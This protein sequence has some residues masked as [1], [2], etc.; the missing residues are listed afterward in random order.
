MT[1]IFR[2]LGKYRLAAGMAVLMMLIELALELIQPFLIAVI[3]DEG[4]TQKDT[5]VVLLWGGL[6]VGGSIVAFGAGILSSFFA[7]HTSQGFAFDIR[8]ALYTKVQAFSYAVFNRFATSSLITRLTND[9]TQLLDTVFMGLRFML[10]MPLVVIGSIVMALVV[11]LQLGLLLTLT[12][13]ALLVFVVWI[14]KKASVL[15][16]KV[17][18]KLDT[19]NRVMQENLTGMRLIRVFVRRK[20]EAGRFDRLSGELMGSTVSALRLT[21]MTMPFILLIMNA[22]IIAVL[23]FGH[24]QIGVGSATSGEV[25]AV[26]NYSLRTAGALSAFSMIVATLSRARASAQRID[27]ALETDSK[28]RVHS[29]HIPVESCAGSVEFDQVSFLYPHTDARVL[30]DISFKIQPGETAAIMGATGS[31]KSSLMQLVLRLY[32]QTAGVVRIDGRDARELDLEFL[33]RS[34]GYVS[35]EVLLFSGTIR[36]NIAWGLEDASMEQVVEAA[37]MAQIHET[38][39]KLP[40]GYQT[41]LGQRGINLSGGQKQ[42]LSIARALIRKPAILLLDDSTSALDVRTEAAL[43]H[44]LKEMA[45]TTLLI[46]QKISSTVGADQILLL[47]EGSLIAQGTHEQ[48]MAGNSLYR[49][50]YESQFGKEGTAHVGSFK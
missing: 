48:L 45:C 1:I 24:Q 13:P 40:D 18:M 9:V 25:V 31:G 20:E 47:D 7:S 3:I 30:T 46:T 10:R 21:E 19:V 11:H 5:S 44:A 50:I 36:D 22:G 38:I 35:Q 42:R 6:L 43:L 14:M 33:H 41:Q 27:E 26:V 16:K 28:A 34:I 12:V 8:E 29:G 32:E 4:I 17:Q 2:Y 23:W 37:R 15:F 39:E 49:R